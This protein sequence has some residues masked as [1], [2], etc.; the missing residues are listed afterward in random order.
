MTRR[1]GNHKVAEILKD[2]EDRLGNLE[3]KDR[4]ASTPNLLRNASDRVHVGDT[5]T[6]VNEKALDTAEW[7]NDAGGWRTATWG[8]I[9]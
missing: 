1:D 6:A 4:S 3:E 2:L 5:V 8:S 7:N 9:E